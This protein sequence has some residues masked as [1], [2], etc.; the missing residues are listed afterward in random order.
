MWFEVLPLDDDVSPDPSLVTPFSTIVKLRQQL[1]SGKGALFLG[2]L[3]QAIKPESLVVDDM[4]GCS[5]VDNL[6][7]KASFVINNAFAA[8]MSRDTFRACIADNLAKGIAATQPAHPCRF[9]RVGRV[10]AAHL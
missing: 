2:F 9:F 6:C 10:A 4:G 7:A 1:K 3:T 8:T 5:E